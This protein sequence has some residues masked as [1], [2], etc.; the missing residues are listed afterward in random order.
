MKA[1]E[2]QEWRRLHWHPIHRM[3]IINIYLHILVLD[4]F[5]LLVAKP[6]KLASLG[7]LELLAPTPK[8]LPDTM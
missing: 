8:A 2:L 6:K 4:I 5:V 3:P 1:A 7:L